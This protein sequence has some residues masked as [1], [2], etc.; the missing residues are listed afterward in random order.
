M[1]KNQCRFQLETQITLVIFTEKRKLFKKSIEFPIYRQRK[2]FVHQSKHKLIQYA[3]RAES[4]PFQKKE[5]TQCISK[6]YFQI[7][8]FFLLECI[9]YTVHKPWVL[10]SI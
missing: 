10:T 4:D 5:F 7:I 9:K 1:M 3:K 6:P 2:L 8:I